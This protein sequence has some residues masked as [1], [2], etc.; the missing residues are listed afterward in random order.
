MPWFEDL[1]DF[2][3]LPISVIDKQGQRR[4]KQ[5]GLLQK[6]ERE[7]D[8]SERHAKVAGDLGLTIKKEPGDN[9]GVGADGIGTEASCSEGDS[10]CEIKEIMNEDAVKENTKANTPVGKTI[11]EDLRILPN[12]FEKVLIPRLTDLVSQTWD[13]LSRRQC[14]RLHQLLTSWAGLWPTFHSNSR[15]VQHLFQAVIR[16]LETIIQE[17]V[18]IPLYPK[19]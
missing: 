16:R 12:I 10:T 6:G 3:R 11:Q 18:F 4:Q 17:D 14:L 5:P 1:I 9:G 8:Q 19:Q 13:P 7:V 15:M 2:T